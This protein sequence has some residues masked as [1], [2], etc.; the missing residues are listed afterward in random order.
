VLKKQS[1]LISLLYSV[2]LVVISFVKINDI[3]EYVP[4]FSDKIVHFFL[5]CFLTLVWYNAFINKFKCNHTA[6]FIWAAIIAIAF[7]II[8]EVLQG[9]L[10]NTRVSDLND[11]LANLIGIILAV[12]L[13]IIKNKLDVKNL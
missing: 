2:A 1:L 12:S 10:T 5:Y 4:S 3:E 6:S 7:G 9:R 13:L 8:I 11:V